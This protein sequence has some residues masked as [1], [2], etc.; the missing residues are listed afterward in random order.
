M[1]KE[2]NIKETI[3]TLCQEKTPNIKSIEKVILDF[4]SKYPKSDNLGFVFDCT[5]YKQMCKSLGITQTKKFILT[6]TNFNTL[7]KTFKDFCASNIPE[8]QK[9]VLI[10]KFARNFAEL[11][12]DEE[13]CENNVHVVIKNLSENKDFV[14]DNEYDSW[15][16]AE[17]DIDNT[18]IGCCDDFFLAE[19]MWF[20]LLCYVRDREYDFLKNFSSFIEFN[21][22]GLEKEREEWENNHCT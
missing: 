17:K 18:Y 1:Y 12:E 11:S 21:A 19:N 9:T 22:D 15:E 13:C 7:L 16:E 10:L 20:P 4:F 14:I 2:P 5:A 8:T 3:L 6:K